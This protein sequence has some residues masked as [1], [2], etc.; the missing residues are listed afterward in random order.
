[1]NLSNILAANYACGYIFPIQLATFNV[2]LII[3]M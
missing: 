1:M 3:T 2:R